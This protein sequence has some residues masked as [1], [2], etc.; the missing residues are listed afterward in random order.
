MYKVLVIDDDPEL[1]E[2]MCSLAKRM[3]L[4]C[5]AAGS[6]A[7]GLNRLAAGGYDVVLLDVR[8]PDGNGLDALPRIRALPDAPEVIILTGQGDPDG[9][10][11]AIQGGVWD[12]LLKPSPVGQT[13][14]SLKRA[15]K[16]R[17]EKLAAS[18][19]GLPVALNLD[20]V[21]GAG[22][23]MRPLFDL[24]A[25]AARSN[26]S[27]L[28]TGE[29]GVGKE[30]FARTIHANSLRRQGAFVAVDCAALTETLIESTLFGHRRG[31]FTGAEADRVGLIT[32][33]DRGTLFLDEV[34][35]LPLAMQKSFLRVL[36]EKRFRP[37]GATVEIESD[38][39]IIV[40]TN[41]DLEAL[42][43]AGGFRSDLLFR[44][45]GICLALPPLRARLEDLKA[46]ARYRVD[47]L[48]EAY[49]LPPK[50]LDEDVLVILAA[51]QWPGNVRELFT[52][53]ER[54]CLAADREKTLYPMHLPSELRIKAT[55][56]S[57]EKSRVE[58]TH[59]AILE[60]GA[61]R[62]SLFLSLRE[63]KETQERGYLAALIEAHGRDVQAMF[64]LS[65]L[66][67]S[68]F[69]ALLKKYGL[70]LPV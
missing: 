67:R 31:S 2:T 70:S 58:E 4:D 46:L 26:T 24:V 66:S 51:H 29:T 11:L 1:R 44:L 23:A 33:A 49:G 40:A 37:V 69:Y 62:M 25:Q 61:P 10:E 9:A 38:F 59:A 8:L 27:V 45:Q 14:F 47:L 15:L 54:A 52:V 41:R 18:S 7:A 3:G 64:A 35:E 57:L 19:G 68:H 65:G 43:R 21:I 13:M 5:D 60:F 63:F 16:Y 20:K 6:L 32:L 39:R 30:L 12:Y 42:A 53:L 34:G 28:I 50:T 55:R 17:E 56:A 36:Q 48:C 22:L